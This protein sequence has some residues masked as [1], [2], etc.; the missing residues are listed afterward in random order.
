MKNNMGIFNEEL[1]EITFSILA[2]KVLGDNVK[3]DFAHMNNI[4]SLLPLYRDVKDDVMADQNILHSLSGRHKI[5]PNGEEIHATVAFFRRTIRQITSN[6]HRSY[7]GSIQSYQSSALASEHMVTID[8]PLVYMSW[9]QLKDYVDRAFD[10]IE[11]DMGGFFVFPNRDMWPE[12]NVGNQAHDDDIHLE[13]SESDSNSSESDHADND[14]NSQHV[15][16]SPILAN[17]DSPHEDEESFNE[18]L[19]MSEG[20]SQVQPRDRRGWKAWGNVHEQNRMIGPRQRQQVDRL[21]PSRR[22]VRNK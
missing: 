5:D 4:F 8:V 18:Q 2:Q 16:L 17:I 12:S 15:P 9:T 19:D 14:D 3:D 22:R 10:G 13:Y 11:H 1:G 20:N 7:D 6:T 21:L